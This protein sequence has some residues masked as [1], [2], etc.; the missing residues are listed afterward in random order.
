MVQPHANSMQRARQTKRWSARNASTR[1]KAQC[2][3]TR[4]SAR[5]RRAADQRCSHRTLSLSSGLLHLATGRHSNARLNPRAPRG[6]PAAA[7]LTPGSTPGFPGATVGA[8]AAGVQVRPAEVVLPFSCAHSDS[9]LAFFAAAQGLGRA[10]AS[11]A[12]S[13]CVSV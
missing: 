8:L 2:C 9:T 1:L 11:W 7:G 12:P 3:G 10:R 4:L 13:A 6:G 5:S